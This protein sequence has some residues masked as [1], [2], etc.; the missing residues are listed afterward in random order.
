MGHRIALPRSFEQKRLNTWVVS[1]VSHVA[2]SGSTPLLTR[3]SFPVVL[4]RSNRFK[5]LI[6]DDDPVVLTLIRER[7]EAAGHDV[8]TRQDAL[9]TTQWVGANHPDFV[10]LDVSMPA[11]SGR[12]LTQLL[13]QRDRTG[14]VGV[15][16]FSGIP[17][18]ELEHQVRLSGAAGGISK[19]VPE[20]QFRLELDRIIVRHLAASQS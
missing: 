4:T 18:D 13:R 7:L 6:V 19:A 11:L 17:A 10:L 2:G 12:E 14:R 20:H 8:T 16:L 5:F 15:I 9:G 1:A 3:T